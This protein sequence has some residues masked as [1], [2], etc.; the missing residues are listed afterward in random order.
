MAGVG[1]TVAAPELFHLVADEPPS[2]QHG[3]AG[4]VGDHNAA[5]RIPSRWVRL[6]SVRQAADLSRINL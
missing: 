1:E 2:A 6:G 3:V 5:D 4:V